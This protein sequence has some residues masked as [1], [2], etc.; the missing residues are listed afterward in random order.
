[1]IC[2]SIPINKMNIKR[3]MAAS[4]RQRACLHHEGSKIGTEKVLFASWVFLRDR[5]C[6]FLRK[7]V[8][9]VS[10]LRLMRFLCCGFLILCR[11]DDGVENDFLFWNWG[12]VHVYVLKNRVNLSAAVRLAHTWDEEYESCQRKSVHEMCMKWI[13]LCQDKKINFIVM[14]DVWYSASCRVL[15][16][17]VISKDVFTPGSF[18]VF[19]ITR[20]SFPS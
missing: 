11:G 20:C 3:N 10:V 9:V 4:A 15:D 8:D 13:V 7:C 16:L 14:W 18:G 12:H 17:I 19:V 5:P 2:G 6:V 1:M